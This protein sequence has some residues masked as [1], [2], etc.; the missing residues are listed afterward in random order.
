MAAFWKGEGRL[1]GESISLGNPRA[2]AEGYAPGIVWL[3]RINRYIGAI[4]CKSAKAEG[5]T[6]VQEFP[7]AKNLGCRLSSV[8]DYCVAIPSKK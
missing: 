6:D 2:Y 5:K 3:K 1:R 4:R 7:N 8:F